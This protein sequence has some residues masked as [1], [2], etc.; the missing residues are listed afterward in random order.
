MSVTDIIIANA[1]FITLCT[2]IHDCNARY[3]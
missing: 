3:H 1:G 2:K